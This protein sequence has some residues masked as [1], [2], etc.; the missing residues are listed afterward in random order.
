MIQV[1]SGLPRIMLLG[2]L[3]CAMVVTSKAQNDSIFTEI[4]YYGTGCL[5]IQRGETAIITDPYISNLSTLQVSFGKVKTDKKYVELYINPGALRKV[6]MVVAGNSRYNHLLDLPHISKYISSDTPFLVNH[7]GKHILSYYQLKQ[8]LVVVND[9]AGTDR[10]EG[11]WYY[12]TD[13]TV[14]AMAFKSDHQQNLGGFGSQNR[15]YSSDVSRE[16]ILVSDWQAGNT[17]SYLID[18]LEDDIVTYRMLFM[19]SGAEAPNGMFPR[20]L[21]NEHPIND[22]FISASAGLDFDDYPA[23][24]IDLCSPERV[25]LI[26]WERSGIHKEAQMKA[27]D[28]KDLDGLKSKLF[29]LYG[30]S[31]EV[32]VPTPLNYY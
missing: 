1:I 3:L 23:P 15:V 10:Q 26:H 22:L 5:S 24:L 28:Q 11:Y 7:S 21:V 14:R 6:K 8:Q 17:Y 18:F 19:S 9:I 16:P 4:R 20:K 29:Q 30:D 12:S 13:G 25:F 31:F 2:F 32:I 27:L